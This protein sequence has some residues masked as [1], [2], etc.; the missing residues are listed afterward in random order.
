MPVTLRW[1][2]NLSRG[3]K[4]RLAATII[5]SLAMLWPSGAIA[6]E[7]VPANLASLLTG[8]VYQGSLYRKEIIRKVEFAQANGLLGIEFDDAEES[9][10]VTAI[11]PLRDI[12]D[13]N[14]SGAIVNLSCRRGDCIILTS[15]NFA[16]AVAKLVRNP[17]AKL[18]R[19]Q[20]KSLVEF[21]I[22]KENAR[23][24]FGAIVT[25]VKVAKGN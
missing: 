10:P 16:P 3:T 7:D 21:G 6:Q 12:N 15:E 20:R 2:T 14:L 11:I 4:F 8:H 18:T 23:A 9:A 19:L 5:L 24:I 13:A 22:K 17:D 1:S 25:L